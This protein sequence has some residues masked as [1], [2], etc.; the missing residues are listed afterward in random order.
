M[1]F[2]DGIAGAVEGAGRPLLWGHGLTSCRTD[3]DRAG[4]FPWRDVPDVELVRWDAPGH[5]DSAPATSD[6]DARWP[7]LADLMLDIADRRGVGR[8]VAGGAS[9]GC[10]TS[11]WA[12]VKAPERIDGLLLVIPPTAW[13]TRAAQ[14]SIYR[15]AA[16][17]V[18]RDGTGAL[19][20][21]FDA[22]P[23]PPIFEPFAEQVRE[24]RR[25]STLAADPSSLAHV[26]RAAVA[27]DLP[28]VDE[29]R[30]LTMPALV[31][32]WDGDP[33][34]PTSTAE[35]LADT[36]PQAQLAIAHDLA[37]IFTWRGRFAAWLGSFEPTGPTRSS[38]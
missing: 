27:S 6:D 32:A 31:L 7:R 3:E 33:G 11:L 29:L 17:V 21:L 8:F 38:A 30:A 2:P 5:G 13:A 22:E 34:H 35:V 1:T 10:A 12:A 15:G 23:L 26:L 37:G 19:A 16:E 28:S 20:D 9:M 36:L 24:A 4:L 25:A 14:A 18:T